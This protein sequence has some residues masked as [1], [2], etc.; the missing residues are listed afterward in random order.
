MYGIWYMYLHEWLIL[1]W[2]IHIA[3]YTMY[4]PDGI[5]IYIIYI[6]IHT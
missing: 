1:L 4:G 5:Y 3:K 2:Y 6:Y